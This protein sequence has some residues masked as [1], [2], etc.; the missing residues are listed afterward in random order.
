MYEALGPSH[1]SEPN[2]N[3]QS[4][5]TPRW[6][7]AGLSDWGPELIPWKGHVS[8]FGFPLSVSFYQWS[9]IIH[10]SLTDPV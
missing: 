6:L 4:V 2:I 5:P 8:V 1:N 10:L 9:V 7:V 3:W